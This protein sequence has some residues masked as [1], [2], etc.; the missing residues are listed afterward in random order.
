[1]SEALAGTL[2]DADGLPYFEP[3][4]CGPTWKR[5][6]EWDGAMAAEEFVIPARTIGWQAIEWV[7]A[8]LLADD[9]TDE[10]PKP[11]ILT[12]EQKRFLLWWY[13]IDEHGVFSYRDGVLQRLKGWG[14][15]PLAAVLSA[16][17]FVGPCRFD[18]WA[19]EDMPEL[20]LLAGEPIAKPH[21]RAWIQI[22]AVSKDQTRNT[23]TIFPGLFSKACI[24]QHGIDIGKEI[25]Y[26]YAGQRRIEAVT[27]S[28][29]ALE[30][31]RPT[32]VLRNETHHWLLSNDGH[33]MAAVIERNATKSKDGAARALSIT[34]AYEPSEDSVAQ[35]Q[36]EAWETEMAGLAIETGVLYDSLEAPAEA[37]L[38]PGK[39][40]DGSDPT[41]DEVKAYIAAV[42]RGVRGDATWLNVDRIVASV[43]DRNNPPSRS[44]R[45]FYNQVV[46]SE[47]AW[48]D[49]AAVEAAVDPLVEAERSLAEGAGDVLRAGWMIR[50]SEEVVMFF[51]GSKS[52]DA[53]ALVGCRL[54][55]GYVYTIG[56]WQKPP[57]FAGK[58]WLVP[59][60][61]VDNRVREA[62]DRF[63]IVAFFGDPSHTKDDDGSRYWDG[64]IDSWH[65]DFK[66][67]LQF[68]SQKAG[69]APHS[70]LWDMAS[71]EKTKA[72][73]GAAEVFN[74][75]LHRKNADD[76]YAPAF[77]HDGHPALRDHLKNA[78]RYP[79][80]HGVSLWKGGRE[81]SK[82]IDLAVAAVGAR[83]LRRLVLNKGL[84]EPPKVKAGEVWH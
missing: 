78:R 82:K 39:H 53:T 83:L 22:A 43:L 54:S 9:S 5:N 2:L 48:A 52:D 45:F 67:R 15:D 60:N 75:E 29:R 8:N 46:A 3:V 76:E 11:F 59:R 24:A 80:A 49:P 10:D 31:G 27:S 64:L 7:E 47:D 35:H 14:K 44:R 55:D 25:I 21:P 66:D 38:H 28:P 69:A 30:G 33:A 4:H 74:E 72:F 77:T 36:R 62:F 12:R 26:A 34:N 13:A 20:G 16:I 51:D 65:R 1:V 56:V 63:K 18:R 17:E 79:T 58:G 32:F 57:G 41:D 73:I 6:P 84:E 81:S 23:M 70:I 68:W 19:T 71:P 40:S 42:I 37:K 50:P 61:E